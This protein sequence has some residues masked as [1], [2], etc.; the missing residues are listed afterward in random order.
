MSGIVGHMSRRGGDIVR[1][2]AGMKQHQDHV[3]QEKNLSGGSNVRNSELDVRNSGTYV[4]K[5]GSL[6]G[7]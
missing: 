3:P 6:S 2:V 7:R 5:G 4:R 1:K